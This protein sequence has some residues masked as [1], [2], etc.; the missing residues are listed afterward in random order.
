MIVKKKKKKLNFAL[1]VFLNQIEP[2]AFAFHARPEGTLGKDSILINLI[3]L[4]ITIRW[5]A[6]EP[7]VTNT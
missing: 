1:S 7:L 2:V 5:E 6:I 4:M 3:L